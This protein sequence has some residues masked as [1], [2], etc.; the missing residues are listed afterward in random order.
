MAGQEGGGAAAL[1]Q[2][3][4]TQR[5]DGAEQFNVMG[6]FRVGTWSAAEAGIVSVDA[7]FRH[8]FSDKVEN[9]VAAAVLAVDQLQQGVMNAYILA[10]LGTRAETALA[11]LRQ[12]LAKQSLGEEKGVL[13]VTG[14]M[15]V[16]H[17]RDAGGTLWSVYAQCVGK[18]WHIGIYPVAHGGTWAPGCRFFSLEA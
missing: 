11:Y 15:N 14:L 1:L 16:F 6:Y 12:L 5:V 8:V 3:I 18:G 2:R 10:T 17:A 4:G 9:R 13:V 7:A